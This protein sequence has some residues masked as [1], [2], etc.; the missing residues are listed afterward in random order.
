MIK[1]K[2]LGKEIKILTLES[3]FLC[4]WDPFSPYFLLH[5]SSDVGEVMWSKVQERLHLQS[6]HL[7]QD[8]TV[9]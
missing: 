8:E 9:I 2:L 1:I 7:F 5:S 4:Q 3:T 6:G